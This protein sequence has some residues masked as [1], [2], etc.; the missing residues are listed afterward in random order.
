LKEVLDT[1]FLVEYFSSQ[2]E[3]KGKTKRKLKDLIGKNEGILP[4][5]VITENCKD[6][7]CAT[8][9]GHSRKSLPSTNPK[10]ITNPK[11]DPCNCAT[12]RASQKR[13]PK[14]TYGRLYNC[15]NNHRKSCKNTLR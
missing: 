7:L 4:T 11:L 1:R 13:L 2:T 5:M 14:S 10:W 15:C 8:G 9:K 3:T 12:G 6:Y